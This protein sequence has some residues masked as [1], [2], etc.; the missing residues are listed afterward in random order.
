ME[1]MRSRIRANNAFAEGEKNRV[2]LQEKQKQLIDEQIAAFKSLRECCEKI[3]SQGKE[4][5]ILY[6]VNAN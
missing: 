6:S 3:N 5:V 2:Q 4:N 1:E